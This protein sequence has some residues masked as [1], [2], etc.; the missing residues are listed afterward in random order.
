[1]LNFFQGVER[2]KIKSYKDLE[3]VED[4]MIVDVSELEP[5]LMIRAIDFLTGLT[6]KNGSLMK[7]ERHKFLVR[8]GR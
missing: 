3:K 6:C 8:F 7:V 4:N 1:M 5:K 2:M